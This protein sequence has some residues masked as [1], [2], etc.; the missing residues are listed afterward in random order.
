MPGRSAMLRVF[1]QIRLPIVPILCVL[2]AEHLS[3]QTPQGSS[4]ASTK[5]AAVEPPTGLWAAQIATDGITLLWKPVAG[6]AGYV[7]YR[8]GDT[9]PP[10][11]IAR[12]PA[13][14]SRWVIPFSARTDVSG[15]YQIAT[16]SA[17]RQVSA[18][19]SFN[20]IT[21]DPTAKV[22]P[23][24]GPASVTA[25]QTGDHEVTVKW[26]AVAG[27]TAYMISRSV[28]PNGIVALCAVCPTTT[29]Y[30]DAAA[31]PGSRHVYTVVTLSPHGRSQNVASPPLLVSGAGKS[32]NT[33]EVK[34]RPAP[35]TGAKATIIPSG[36]AVLLTWTSSAEAI[37][38]SVWRSLNGG[39]FQQIGRVAATAT[40][41]VTYLDRLPNLSKQQQ[42]SY[43]IIAENT[44]GASPPVTVSPSK[45]AIQ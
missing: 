11:E 21:P 40:Q 35:V 23:V 33:A 42:V 30:V 9:G 6:A 5:T 26:A 8:G 20:E 7:I 10:V 43:Q 27:A 24:A 3:A 32:Q 28:A 45:A 22:A 29:T 1:A 14:S 4:N 36:T 12:P 17:D 16:I 38:Y 39:V 19:A 18:R 15:R 34:D 44:K 13:S 2:C 25:E 31:V 37:S 41:M